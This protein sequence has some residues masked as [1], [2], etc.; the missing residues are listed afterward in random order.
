MSTLDSQTVAAV[1]SR[2]SLLGHFKIARADHW[3]KNVFVVPGIV[4]AVSMDRST[5]MSTLTWNVIIGLLSVCLVT[6]SNYVLNEVLDAP[7]D[8]EHPT[9]FSR[10]VPSGE[11]SIPLAYLQ[12][13][14]L[15]IA[16]VGLGL[17]ISVTFALTM[18][19]LWL[20]ACVYNISPIRSKD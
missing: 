14:M 9:K 11:V 7:Y 10:P 6:S 5:L 17:L 20:M 4:V 19:V 16:G 18:L 1:R 3:I 8:R 12:W 15:M 13:I 2:P